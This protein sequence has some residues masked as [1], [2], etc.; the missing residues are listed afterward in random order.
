M[1]D[2]GLLS[3]IPLNQILL[4]WAHVK[5]NPS[6][7]LYR[8]CLTRKALSS[9]QFIA[10]AE[11]EHNHAKNLRYYDHMSCAICETTIY[12]FEMFRDC[13]QGTWRQGRSVKVHDKCLT[14]HG[15]YLTW[16]LTRFAIDMCKQQ[17][18]SASDTASVL[19]NTP[20]SVRPRPDPS[21][22][23]LCVDTIEQRPTD[24]DRERRTMLLLDT[25]LQRMFEYMPAEAADLIDTHL[26]AFERVEDG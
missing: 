10:P 23:I 24:L 8:Q 13:L 5:Y 21:E 25:V 9:A 18:K 2:S 19:N 26:Q 4:P 22:A 3:Q 17:D 20:D 11:R 1:C 7:D 12:E 16:C 15:S 6:R 14:L